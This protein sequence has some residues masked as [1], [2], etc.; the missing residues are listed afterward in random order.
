M[1]DHYEILQIHPTAD[2]EAI[3]AAYERLGARH[4]PA[5]LEGAADDLVALTR[6]KRDEIERA[7]AVLSD[8]KRRASYDAERRRAEAAPGSGERMPDYRPLPPAQ[9]EER[10][11]TFDAQPTVAADA[12]ATPRAAGQKAW[13][14]PAATVGVLTFVIILSGLLLTTAFNQSG[15]ADEASAVQQPAMPGADTAQQPAAPANANPGGAPQPTDAELQQIVAEY[16]GQVVAARQVVGEL[17]NNQNAWIRLANALYDSTQVVRELRPNSDMYAERS[18]RWL[19]ASEA[20]ATALELGATDP[21][22]R[23]DMGVSLCYYSNA[24][25]ETEYA[26]QGMQHTAR[27]LQEA[28]QNGRVL[29]N[30]GLCLVS[31]QPPQVD[32]AL[33]LWQRVIE[34]PAAELGVARQ[35]QRL[36]EEYSQ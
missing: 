30:H 10:P 3:Q 31:S 29:L 2:Q 27:A 26:A 13:L 18:E 22:V 14:L 21:V 24:S 4:D 16:D 17:P 9:G 1:Q 33:S 12:P 35:A 25:G 32:E 20:Y 15:N 36:V 7:Y 6:R 34:M 5:K 23:S 28:G 19:E 11:R 8:T